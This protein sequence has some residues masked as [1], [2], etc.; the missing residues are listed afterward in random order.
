MEVKINRPPVPFLLSVLVVDDHPVFRHGLA[1]ILEALAFVRNVDQAGNGNEAMQLVSKKKY[2]IILLDL[3]M[4]EKDGLLFLEE[5]RG[6]RMANKPKVIVISTFSDSSRVNA[7]REL[8]VYGYIMKDTPVRELRDA[9]MMV[10]EGEPYF[11][12]NIQKII[13]DHI[14]K[15]K[16]YHPAATTLTRQEKL[17]LGMICRQMST[18]QIAEALFLSEKTIKRHRSKIRQKSGTRNTAGMI[19]FAVEHGIY[20]IGQ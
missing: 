10:A 18:K 20:T 7:A 19:T 17:V 5:L 6:K 12:A 16:F 8:G 1:D 13:M 15:T 9:L 3:S 2:D 11:S 4:P 14:V